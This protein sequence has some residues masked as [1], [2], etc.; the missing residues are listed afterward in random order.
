[1]GGVA[2]CITK[3]A[4]LRCQRHHLSF[5]QR[6]FLHLSCQQAHLAPLTHT[7]AQRVGRTGWLVG[8]YQK[9]N[10]AAECMAKGVPTREEEDVP[11]RLH[12]TIAMLD[13]PIGWQDGVWP[14]RVGVAKT[15]ER[16]AH[17]Q[18]V[19]VLELPLTTA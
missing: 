9:R 10:G 1:M 2:G 13:S 5:H 8:Q 6:L 15:E 4:Q 14:R 7:I 18:Q 17:R 16:A 19:D 12:P 11:P 3:L